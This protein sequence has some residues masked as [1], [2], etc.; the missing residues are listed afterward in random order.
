MALKVHRGDVI[1]TDVIYRVIPGGFIVLVAHVVGFGPVEVRTSRKGVFSCRV[2]DRGAREAALR[3]V[4]AFADDH[5][6]EL[7][8]HYD[9]IA[10]SWLT[11]RV[12]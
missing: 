10:E 9:E 8:I 3:A 2:T 1:M 7:Q 4:E 6:E 5:E 12:A 11:P